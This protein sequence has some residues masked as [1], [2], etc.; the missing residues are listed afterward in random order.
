MDKNIV[1]LKWGDK[2]PSHYVNVLY[3]MCKRHTNSNFNFF[4][5]TD[6]PN[7]LNQFIIDKP[8]PKMPI[9]GW[10]MKPFVFSRDNNFKGD[11]LFLDLDLIIHNNF[12][13]LW[14]YSPHDF[15]I[16]RDFTRKLNPK[17]QKYNSSVFRFNAK[18]YYWI[19]EDFVK[20]HQR[21]ITKNHGDQ[22]YLYSIL[23]GKASTWP[24]NWIQSYKWEMRNRDEVRSINGKRN[25]VS[26]KDP[27][28]VQDNCIAVFHGE[29][30]PHDV[31]DP[32]VIENWQ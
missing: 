2:Y 30:N 32:W 26:I 11:V 1:C 14:T 15:C 12:D 8:L 4:C 13:K 7:G 25:F 10:W 21:I 3:N 24:D 22:D 23:Q 31:K 18:N 29:P 27:Y 20:N 16:I 19:W 28:I 9:Q 6:N 5:L 17:W